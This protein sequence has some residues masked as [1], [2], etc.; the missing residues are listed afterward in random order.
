MIS[1]QKIRNKF[2]PFV[3]SQLFLAEFDYFF[4]SERFN[5]LVKTSALFICSDKYLT[6]SV[7]IYSTCNFSQF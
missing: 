3:L 2:W 4:L 5:F 7:D 1:W 6:Y